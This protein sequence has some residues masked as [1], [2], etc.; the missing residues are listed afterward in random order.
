MVSKWPLGIHS[1]QHFISTFLTSMLISKTH[2]QPVSAILLEHFTTATATDA[3]AFRYSHPHFSIKSYG[4]W[5]RAI[6]SMGTATYLR[7]FYLEP[8]T[9]RALITRRESDPSVMQ[10]RG[11]ADVNVPSGGYRR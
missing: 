4:L 5:N 10:S 8:L 9:L 6:T 11:L 1:V 3:A 7:L 2:E